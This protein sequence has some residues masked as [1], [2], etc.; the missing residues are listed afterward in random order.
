MISPT[1]FITCAHVVGARPSDL[2][3][4]LCHFKAAHVL[5][6]GTEAR[7]IHVGEEIPI[8][9]NITLLETS[10]P[11]VSEEFASISSTTNQNY[12]Q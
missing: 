6:N 8:R 5:V 2:K 12:T 4:P 11:I 1:I 9:E 3:H 10:V 7:P